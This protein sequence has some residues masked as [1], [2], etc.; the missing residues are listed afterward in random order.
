[1]D[2]LKLFVKLASR[3]RYIDSAG[4]VPLAIF[5]PLYDARGLAALGTVRALGSVHH[6][7]TICRL[8]DLGHG[9]LLSCLGGAVL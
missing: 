8:G 2:Q 3:A 7:F 1:M 5:H 9:R 4:D 6:F